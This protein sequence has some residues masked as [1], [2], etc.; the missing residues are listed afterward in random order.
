MRKNIYSLDDIGKILTYIPQIFLIVF[1]TIL[2]IVSYFVIEYKQKND[3]NLLLEQQ[4]YIN[5]KILNE[6]ISQVNKKIEKYLQETESELKKN[7]YILKGIQ[8]NLPNINILINKYVKDIEQKKNVKFVIFDTN[9]NIIYGEKIVKDI[10]EL[11]FNQKGDETY[12]GLTLLYLSSQGE[13]TSFSW[14]DDLRETIQLSYIEKSFDK[15]YFIGAFSYVDYQGNLIQKAFLNEIKENKSTSNNYY[16]WIY[17]KAYK[18]A[19]NLDNKKKWETISYINKKDSLYYDFQRYNLFIGITQKPEFLNRKIEE[20]KIKYKKQH[21][22]NTFIILLATLV[23]IAFTTIFSSFIKK[24]FASYNRNYENK[25]RQ[26]RRIKQRYELAIIA[27][28]DGLWDR[29]LKT[30][31]IFFSKKW[32]DMLGYKAG[33]IKNY[34][35]WL[36]LLHEKD[37][38]NIEQIIQDYIEQ[39][40]DEH[41]I[42]EYRLKMKNGNYKWIL[43]RG[44]V[45]KDDKND[46][47][48]LLMMTMDIDDK[49]ETTKKLKEL[50]KKEVAKNEEKQRLLIQQNKLA[51]MG[52]MIGAIAHQWRQPLNNISLILHFIRDN[53]KQE[54][55]K[56]TQLNSFIEKAKEQIIYMSQTIDDFRD[57]YKP[58]KQIVNFDIKKAIQSTVDIMQTQIN[59]YDI[60]VTIKGKSLHVD[61]YENEFK[62][63]ILNILSNAKDAISLKEKNFKARIDIEIFEKNN[64]KYITIFNNAGNIDNSIID[65][66]FEPYFTTKFETKGT[67]IGLYMTKTI[68]ETSMEGE[69]YVENKDDGVVFTI[70]LKAFSST[71]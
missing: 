32:L 55:F 41:L 14:K 44:K 22:F 54:N 60:E 4:K 16:F 45:F 63:A 1:A 25:N 53:I 2:I 26:L 8:T 46:R 18:K 12:I 50:V 6:Y 37:R 20:I 42:C 36:E 48:R 52:E 66:I 56:E 70:T 35:G 5:E 29:N 19:F 10:E 24:I 47:K 23:L 11:I 30:G 58:S 69:I 49:K 27:S 51:A 65:R 13:S 71:K 59:K 62:Q 68:I 17:D 38:K 21:N 40:S 39:N 57:F 33:E 43:A 9:L 15:K 67:G 61:G 3:I 34:K 7:V 31:T 28:N 64:K